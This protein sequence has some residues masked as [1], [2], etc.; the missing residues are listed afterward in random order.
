MA[1]AGEDLLQLLGEPSSPFGDFIATVAN[2]GLR[3][4]KTVQQ[5]GKTK[6]GQS[7]YT[8]VLDGV[9]V[10]E[11]VRHLLG[12]GAEETRVLFLAYAVH[13]LNKLPEYDQRQPYRE[14]ASETNIACELERVGANEFFPTWRDYLTDVT[15]L[16][17]LHQGHLAVD[18][19]GLDR[20]TRLT[21]RL[22]WQR[23]ERLGC[24]M[25]AA[26]VLDLS[27][28]LDESRHKETFLHELNVAANGKRYYFIHHRLAESRG[29]LTNLIHQAISD[30]VRRRIGS[31][32]LLHYPEGTIYVMEAGSMIE[33]TASDD[34][35]LVCAVEQAL[36][37]LQSRSVE[38]F[39]KK[40][41]NGY[42]VDAAALESGTSSQAIMALMREKIEPLSYGEKFRRGEP[43][44]RE[45]SVRRELE[46]ALAR[47]GEAERL[48]TEQLLAD[49]N[50][51]P[52]DDR[53]RVGELAQGYCN[54]LDAHVSAQLKARKEKVWHHLYRLLD[55]PPA[56]W[57]IY[58]AVH[59][60]RRSYFMA[61]DVTLGLD[62]LADCIAG[63]LSDLGVNGTTT[64]GAGF[65]AAYLRENLMLSFMPRLPHDFAAAL[66]RYGAD[67]HEQCCYCGS[68]FATSEWMAANVPPNVGVQSF[69]NRLAGGGGEPKRHVCSLCRSQF[70]LEKLA[71]SNH[72]DKRGDEQATFYLHLFPYSYFTAPFLDAW[73]REVQRLVAED[74]TA[75]FIDTSRWLREWREDRSPAVHFKETKVNG[76]A[77]PRPETISNTPVMVVNAPGNSYT[78][79]FLVAL[80]HA[81]VLSQFF[82]CRLI[83]S[84][85]AVPILPPDGFR[86][87]FVDGVPTALN[88]LMWGR[89]APAGDLD[90]QGIHRLVRRLSGLQALHSKLWER[91][92]SRN[93]V[94]ELARAANDNPL[95]M[96]FVADR[97]VEEKATDAHRALQLVQDCAPYLDEL[98][99]GPMTELHSLARMAVEDHV[100]GG[101]GPFGRRPR[102]ALLKPLDIMFNVLQ[103]HPGMREDVHAAAADEVFSHL[104]R[105]AA[106]EYRPG[107]RKEEKVG[108]YVR[109]FLEGVLDQMYDGDLNRLMAD[110]R[111]VRSAYVWYVRQGLAARREERAAE[112]DLVNTAQ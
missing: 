45:E 91:G 42:R 54:F 68:A 95:A 77:L 1:Q 36:Q 7:L 98:M 27:H 100:L 9:S 57:P 38:Q 62:D 88:W 31:A 103:Q 60:F 75:A 24:L 50:L 97:A 37:R 3:R 89:S 53:L 86:S 32:A 43:A 11:V 93:L 12:L 81:A 18:D 30:Y 79:Q 108:R 112:N 90:Q 15:A 6:Q 72:R 65:V 49:P 16:C 14:L 41:Q 47:L 2:C 71:W 87:L 40:A 107:A 5:T 17:R 105:I 73:R 104:Q 83:V 69:S 61:R 19:T 99:E 35:A 80:G 76:V 13:D 22:G 29:I 51:L 84:R 28:D 59:S 55:L 58:D 101:S 10:L 63:D 78:A 48:E 4:Y 109:Q 67:Q 82:G 52:S 64:K 39:V 74:V 23:V 102:S 96:V 26:D 94:L 85:T 8:H 20:R 33:W 56:R 106:E 111:F 46:G 70:I 66:L 92:R 21:Y 25:R 44:R 34:E 110:E